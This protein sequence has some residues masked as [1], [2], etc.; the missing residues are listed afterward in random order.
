MRPVERGDLPT[1][2]G[3]SPKEYAKYQDAR[4]DLI[5]RI[6]PYCSYCGMQLRT[7]LAV[8]HVKP[9]DANP[10]LRIEWTNVLLSCTHCFAIASLLVI[11]SVSWRNTNRRDILNSGPPN[12]GVS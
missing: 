6:G 11:R 5:D 1:D 12:S 9:K 7:S 8:E 3:G 4:P 10:A 2:S